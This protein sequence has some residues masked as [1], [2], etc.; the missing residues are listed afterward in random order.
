MPVIISHRQQP[1]KF[2]NLTNVDN[3]TEN[4]RIAVFCMRFDKIAPR[5]AD[6]FGKIWERVNLCAECYCLS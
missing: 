3:V 5:C 4:L 2:F 1:D 6:E